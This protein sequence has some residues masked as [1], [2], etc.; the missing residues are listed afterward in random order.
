MTRWQRTLTQKES[1]HLY[2]AV[3]SRSEEPART[4]K[5]RR[6]LLLKSFLQIHPRKVVRVRTFFLFY[7]AGHA[8]VCFRWERRPLGLWGSI[9]LSSWSSQL[10]LS[11]RPAAICFPVLHS[12][13]VQYAVGWNEATHFFLFP[14]Q[15]VPLNLGIGTSALCHLV[16]L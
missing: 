13:G 5:S 7:S 11:W 12:D 1:C 4:P 2:T 8:W 16:T 10:N 14:N 6:E 3:A 9:L 15:S